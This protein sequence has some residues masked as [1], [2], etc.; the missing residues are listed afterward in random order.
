MGLSVG[1]AGG[2]GVKR[3]QEQEG[4]VREEGK[5]IAL[6]GGVE[7]SVGGWKR[8]RALESEPLRLFFSPEISV[9]EVCVLSTSRNNSNT[10][11]TPPRLFYQ[12]IVL[13]RETR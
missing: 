10:G 6:S 11:T 5:V 8:R 4:T 7:G 13:Y 9:R 2:R 12:N 3:H 1:A